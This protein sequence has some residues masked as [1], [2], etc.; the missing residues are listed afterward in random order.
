MVWA[1]SAE[2]RS[3]RRVMEEGVTSYCVMLVGHGGTRCGRGRGNLKNSNESTVV[4]EGPEPAGPGA[5]AAQL[6]VDDGGGAGL[7]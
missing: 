7:V 2:R 1:Q 6:G 5:D 4:N 3:D